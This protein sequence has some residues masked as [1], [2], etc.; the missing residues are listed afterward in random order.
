VAADLTGANRN[1]LDYMNNILKQWGLQTL[2]GQ[3][4]KMVQQ[5]YQGD[6]ISYQLSQTNEYKQRFAG[7][8]ARIKNGLAALSPSEYLQTE[9]AYRQVMQSAGLPKGFYDSHDDFTKLIGS[10]ISPTEMKSR[11]DTAAKYVQATDPAT[12]QALQAYYGIDQNHLVAHFLDPNAAQSILDKQSRAADIGAAAQQQGFGMAAKASA[13]RAAD[14]GMT[15]QDAATKYGKAMEVL[16]DE[17]KLSGLYGDRT[18]S[19]GKNEAEQEMVFGLAS[20][21]RKRQNLEGYEK[22]NFANRTAQNPYTTADN[23][24]GSY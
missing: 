14:M 22:A 5:G 3:V 23:T 8:D 13:E 10:D 1:A 20:A 15:G 6:S 2:G 21:N 11:A 19:Y 17:Q 4:L 12:R 24:A 7:N 18:A 9:R 16:P